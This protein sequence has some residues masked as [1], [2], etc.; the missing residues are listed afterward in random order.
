MYAHEKLRNLKMHFLGLEKSWILGRMTEV[1]GNL[2]MEFHIL[3]Q[4]FRAV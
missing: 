3:V 4:R 2:V 1:M